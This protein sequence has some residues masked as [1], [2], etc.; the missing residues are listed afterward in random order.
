MRK[1]F[2]F[3][4]LLILNTFLFSEIMII[5]T[6]SETFEIELSEI[7]SIEFAGMTDADFIE[8]INQINF[9]LNQNHPNPFNPETTISF[10][11]E[12]RENVNLS[13]F[14]LKGQKVKTLLKK[15]LISGQHSKVWTGDNDNGI[16]VASGI[17]FY[18]LTIGEH[19][20]TKKMIMLK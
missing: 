14:N 6:A 12:S 2:V 8:V 10:S 19:T 18:K 16:Q 5:E 15:E 11:I 7:E 20:Q 13:I 3:S 9:R 4:F 17:Y 1:L